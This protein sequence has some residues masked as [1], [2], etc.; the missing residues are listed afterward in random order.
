[1]LT[2]DFDRF[3]VGPG[4]RVLDMGCG[5]G[6][7]AFELARRGA[8][9][10]ALDYSYDELVPVQQMLNAMRAEGEVPVGS[11][12]QSVRGDA[13]RLPFPDDSFDRIVAAEV[14]EHIPADEDAM[15]ELRRVLKP[16]GLISVTVP[17]F[18][19]EKVCWALS[20]DYHEV[21]GGHVRIYRGDELLD[22]LTRTGLEPLGHHHAHALHAPYWWLK[23][24]AGV[25]NDQALLPRTYHKLLVW[26][27]LKAPWITRTAD[28]LLNP[29]VGKSLVVYLRKPAEAEALGAAA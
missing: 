5:G 25:R 10:V 19:P 14:L 20:D 27:I 28:R 23:C 4:H 1:M 2:V 12:T 18:W 3:P 29:V 6:R 11:I 7:H 15:A 21:E 22:K 13:L 16:G 26:D 17:R 9:V 8:D 24:A